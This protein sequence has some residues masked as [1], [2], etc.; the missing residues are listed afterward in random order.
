MAVVMALG[1][2]NRVLYKMVLNPLSD[3]VFFLAQFQTFSYVGV[4]FAVLAYKRYWCAVDYCNGMRSSQ[5]FAHFAIVCKQLC[6]IQDKDSFRRA[7]GCNRQDDLPLYWCSGGPVSG[8]VTMTTVPLHHEVPQTLCSSKMHC[9]LPKQHCP[10]V[11]AHAGAGIHWSVEAAWG[12]HPPV[13]AECADLADRGGPRRPRKKAACVPGEHWTVAL[14]LH[15]G[16]ASSCRSSLFDVL[17]HL[18]GHADALLQIAGALLVVAGVCTAAWPGGDGNSVFSE[19][20]RP[21][22]ATLRVRLSTWSMHLSSELLLP[23]GL[24]L[25]PPLLHMEANVALGL[26]CLAGQLDVCRR[27][28]SEHVLP[29]AVRHLQGAHLH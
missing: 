23:L 4:Y 27:V 17:A 12:G 28:R 26:R 11:M 15:L 29:C 6:V 19:V 7:A 18:R 8:K 2:A 9:Q 5:G 21:A 24:K 10:T 16:I 3:Y 25:D 14:L 20:W 22:L 13:V 1:V